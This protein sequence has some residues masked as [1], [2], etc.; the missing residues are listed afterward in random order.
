M[1]TSEESDEHLSLGEKTV[2][3]FSK[4][5]ILF[6]RA[7]EARENNRFQDSLSYLDS[8]VDGGYDVL[9][10]IAQTLI[11]GIES[12]LP[13]E[14][15][16][17]CL[18]NLDGMDLCD[19]LLSLKKVYSNMQSRF[20]ERDSSYVKKRIDELVREHPTI[21]G[22]RVIPLKDDGLGELRNQY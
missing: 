20:P 3:Y 15:Y 22:K 4:N 10:E 17:G 9:D 11:S 13:L 12:A 6:S 18:S 1:D 14:E 8:V 19:Y 21:E 7:R 5:N 16:T 2:S